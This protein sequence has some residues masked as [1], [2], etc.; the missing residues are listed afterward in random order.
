ML[1]VLDYITR[2]STPLPEHDFPSPVKPA[3]QEQEKEPQVFWQLALTSQ[4]STESRH[5]SISKGK[6]E[7]P[8]SCLYNLKS[9]NIQE[10]IS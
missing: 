4:A 2:V 5:S 9:W 8:Q 6:R 3:L 1:P 7:R 10:Q